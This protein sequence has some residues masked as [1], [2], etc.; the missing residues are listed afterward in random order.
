MAVL[1]S[2][3]FVLSP[4]DPR[5][6]ET[7]PGAQAVLP[8]LQ[9]AEEGGQAAAGLR[10]AERGARLRGLHRQRQQGA[11]DRGRGHAGRVRGQ[12]VALQLQRQGESITWPLA[13]AIDNRRI[14]MTGG[15]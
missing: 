5:V 8:A 12:E 14:Q 7:G 10:G 11:Q 2:W 3:T 15:P 1:L 13:I 6:S 4:G 9:E